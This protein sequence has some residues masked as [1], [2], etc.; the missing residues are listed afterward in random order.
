M[1]TILV[2][3][4]DVSDLPIGPGSKNLDQGVLICAQALE[5]KTQYKLH[6]A[7]I[8]HRKCLLIRAIN[9]MV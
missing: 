6:S 7:Y 3:S 8:L 5:I 4:F 2:G 1:F 9:Q